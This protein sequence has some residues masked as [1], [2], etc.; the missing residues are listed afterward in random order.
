MF[1]FNAKLGHWPYRP[2]RGLDTLLRAMDE[3]GVEQAVVSSLS[4]VHF[5][6]PQDGNGELVDLIAPHRDR[7]IPFAVLRPNFTGWEADLETC[8][9][10]FAMKGVVLYPNY[11]EFALTDPPV[12]DLMHEAARCRLPVCVQAGLE[13][14][15]R[16]FRSYKIDEV[17]A[18]A[19]GDLARAYPQATIVALG[20]KINQPDQA[21]DPLPANLCFDT[22][23][24]EAMGELERAVE[25]FGAEKILLG[26][27]FPLFN[28]RA[29]VDKLRL[30]GIDASAR[31]AIGSENALRILGR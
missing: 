9:D 24:Y 4:A 22:S 16:Q 15:R 11:H 21:G 13:D 2:V 20:L 12:A 18:S 25:K 19:I 23:N 26:S 6:N 5:L 7:L 3:F 14:P 30:A 27:N 8:R 29:N 31:A 28:P 1:D 17:P 10:E